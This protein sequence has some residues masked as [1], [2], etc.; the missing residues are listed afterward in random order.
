MLNCKQFAN[1]S[2]DY[3]DNEYS[4]IKRMEIRFHLLICKHCRRYSRHLT[5]S[6]DTGAAIAKTLWRSDTPSTEKIFDDISQR[7]KQS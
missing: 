7:N 3:I 2:S 1:L 5:H 6:R 4:G